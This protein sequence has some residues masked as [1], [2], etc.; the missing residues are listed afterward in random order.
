V[1]GQRP[2]GGA[3]ALPGAV[4]ELVTAVPATTVV[5]NLA[6]S[7][8]PEAR[9]R[10]EAGELR[11][12]Q[13]AGEQSRSPAGT[14][15]RQSVPA[16]TRVE[17]GTA[18]D[19]VV[20]T[21]V[22]TT[23]PDLLGIELD[24]ARRRLEAA[25]LAVGTVS[26]TESRRPAG[27]V[28]TQSERAG[29]TVVVGTA[30]DLMAAIPMTVVVPDLTGRDLPE[31][32]GL[33]EGLE[34]AV[35]GVTSQESRAPD[36]SV[37]AQQPGAG[38]RAQIGTPVDLVIAEPVTVLVPG[39]VGFR[40]NDALERL[41]GSEL[42]AGAVTRR[43]S[44]QPVATVLEQGIAAGERVVVGTAVGL[45]LAEPMTVLVPEVVG[46]SEANATAA[47]EG[48]ELV[49]GEVQYQES[50]AAVG[51]VLT[52]SLNPGTR[53]QIGSAVNLLVA[54][55]E[56]VPVPAVV[57]QPLEQ[58]R[59]ALVTG[60]LEVGTE[61]L[62]ETRSEPE[63][64][65]LEQSRAAGSVAAVGTPVNLVVATPEIIEVPSVI[66]LSD[67]EAITVIT[68]AGLVVGAVGQQLSLEAGGTVLAQAQ[69]AGSQVVFGTPIGL[70]VARARTVWAVPSALLLLLLGGAATVMVARR[71]TARPRRVEER[72]EDAPP[73][74]E[75]HVEPVTDSG[76][77]S[78]ETGPEPAREGEIRL[79]PRVDAGVQAIE[80]PGELI[81][82]ERSP[83]DD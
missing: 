5:P 26:E 56:T 70:Q 74:P 7:S 25:E 65:V 37:L 20:A 66:G 72:N 68:G 1:I 48:A 38:A 13:I 71:R 6:G 50:P 31:A 41:R 3:R 12:G 19:M 14:V 42:T 61:Q 64:T 34:L 51:T 60:R 75:I 59:R 29:G 10:L 21:P 32:R 76:K 44:R 36:G 43:E 77:Q 2:Q 82:G 28:L 22:T 52:Q 55:V 17:V 81:A 79:H 46:S 40:E 8:E 54:V 47:L 9:R 73:L 30:V 63:G 49:V 18:I 58:A 62:R 83:D 45:V 27:I 33:L 15:L 11:A 39:V 23:V 69:A 35:G 57:G 4:I 24:E 80:S 67:S 53:V 16:G 78:M